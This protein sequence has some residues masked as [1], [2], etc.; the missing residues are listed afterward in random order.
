MK[1][2]AKLV[3]YPMSNLNIFKTSHHLE[4]T[5]NMDGEPVACKT[6]SGTFR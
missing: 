1:V 4:F 6:I 3:H 2:P 5:H